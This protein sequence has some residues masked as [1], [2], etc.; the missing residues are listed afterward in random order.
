M[1]GA[2]LGSFLNVCIYRIP[3]E[4]SV[5]KPRS[6]CPHCEKMIVWYDNI[7]LLSIILLG[8]KCRSCKAPISPR[9]FVVELL[10]GILFLLVWLKWDYEIGDRLLG[11]VPIESLMLVPVYWLFVFGML[12]GTFVDLD[13]LI[14]PDRVSIGGIIIGI[15]LSVAVPELQGQET[16]L[17]S[18]MHSVG[19]A[20]LGSGLLWSVASIG[21]FVFRKPAMGMGDVKLL[22]AIGAFM[23]W[24]AVFFTVMASSLIGSIVGISLVIARK[25]EMQSRIPYGPFLAIAALVWMFWGMN[26]WDWWFNLLVPP[27][28][29]YQ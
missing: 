16:R 28:M 23:G 27:D 6:R 21:S 7:P 24:R 5:V 3:A 11:L 17:Y 8:G 10:T 9:Y 29:Y 26:I 18:L 4:L 13:H 19:G 22:G 2:C 25:K 1:W 20:L 12:L 14:I 15:A